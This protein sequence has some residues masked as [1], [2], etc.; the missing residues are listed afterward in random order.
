MG[1]HKNLG[2]WVMVD[3][4]ELKWTEGDRWRATVSLPAGGIH[5]YKY[6]L[7]DSTGVHAQNWQRG[8]NSV[9]AIKQDETELEVF[10]NWEGQPGAA[11]TAGGQSSTRESKLLAWATDIEAQL[12]SQR[13]E[14]RR[15]R[16]ELAAAQEDARRARQEARVVRMELAQSQ[17]VRAQ[18]DKVI[19]ELQSN[20]RLLKSE[21]QATATTFKRALHVAQTMLDTA[22]EREESMPEIA[23]QATEVAA[24]PS[25][26]TST[27][28][29]TPDQA[30][31]EKQSAASTAAQA[32]S[33]SP[34]T[35]P[36][37][38]TTTPGSPDVLSSSTGLGTNQKLEEEPNAVISTPGKEQDQEVKK[39]TGGMQGSVAE[40]S[41]SSNARQHSTSPVAPSRPK[42]VSPA[43]ASVG[44][45]SQNTPAGQP[46]SSSGGL[47]ESSP[48]SASSSM[49]AEVQAPQQEK[50]GKPSQ[51]LEDLPKRPQTLE[52]LPKHSTSPD[53]EATASPPKIPG[54][55][56]ASAQAAQPD[57]P[58]SQGHVGSG[59]QLETTRTAVPVE[60]E[61]S[62][63]AAVPTPATMDSVQKSV[64]EQT[65]AAGS[66]VPLEVHESNA[67]APQVS[68]EAPNA[69]GGEQHQGSGMQLESG[70]NA[71]PLD[72]EE[73]NAA[74]LE[75][76]APDLQ[77]DKEH[78]YGDGGGVA[79]GE[80]L[81]QGAQAVPTPPGQTNASAKSSRK[82]KKRRKKSQ[83]RQAS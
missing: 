10:D 64:G 72:V 78:V 82:E 62:N 33:A 79:A 60:V 31:T 61:K 28:A 6:V 9:L 42:P 20:N 25:P 59:K 71:V 48:T 47:D 46:T 30:P 4:P 24:D 74:A 68:T 65:E 50:S 76:P 54:G 67:T 53:K 5:E 75:V 38:S 77:S 49:S 26:V 22:E 58:S 70:K 7:L 63:A 45:E 13:Q 41:G 15:S 37:D 56:P 11:V 14:L 43:A 73:S 18:A 36:D 55:F 29:P 19:R 21:L 16:V 2:K 3:G 32:E 57:Q 23:K 27:A 81:M 69:G 39:S 12:E 8:N 83:R 80:E 66:A 40:S 1:S 17:T 44:V 51:T 34:E 35:I 52:D